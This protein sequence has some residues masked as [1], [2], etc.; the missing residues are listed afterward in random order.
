M[1][2][3]DKLEAGPE[4]DALVAE[5]V[6]GWKCDARDCDGVRLTRCGAC[7]RDGHGNCYGPGLGGEIQVSCVDRGHRPNYSGDIAAAWA[8]W[9]H[10]RDTWRATSPRWQS[11]VEALGAVADVQDEFEEGD[12][13]Y[14]GGVDN[15]PVYEALWNLSP[16]AICLAAL[17]ALE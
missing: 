7:G 17:K 14:G 16:R 3:I 2:D 12:R 10:M 13:R 6:T 1:S 15:G 4:L 11:F 9:L 5:K 8:V